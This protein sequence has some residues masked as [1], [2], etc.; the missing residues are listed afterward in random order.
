PLSIIKVGEFATRW[1]TSVVHEDIDTA[2]FAYSSVDNTLQ[3]F[4]PGHIGGHANH[5]NPIVGRLTQTF[6][7]LIQRSLVTCT[8]YKVCPFGSERGSTGT[9]KSLARCQDNCYFTPET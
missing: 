6:H 8:D 5:R 3:I 9:P 4:L 2:K 7:S 1:A